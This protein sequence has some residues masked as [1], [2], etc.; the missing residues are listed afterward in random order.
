MWPKNWWLNCLYFAIHARQ[1]VE[2]DFN[3]GI[4]M[5]FNDGDVTG[6]A[7]TPPHISQILPPD[8]SDGLKLRH[9]DWG[10]EDYFRL[11]PPLAYSLSAFKYTML[12]ILIIL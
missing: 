6:N 12:Q 4:W 8:H 1:P 5:Y 7:C 2:S 10:V 11:V 3:S 9:E